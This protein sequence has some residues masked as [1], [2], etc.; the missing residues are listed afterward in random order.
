MDVHGNYSTCRRSVKILQVVDEIFH[1]FSY[2]GADTANTTYL[3]FTVK[4][5]KFCCHKGMDSVRQGNGL[6]EFDQSL[7]LHNLLIPE[8]LFRYVVYSWQC[9]KEAGIIAGSKYK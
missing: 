1:A 5:R 4:Q 2:I 6:L 8:I 3:A 7:T 9:E